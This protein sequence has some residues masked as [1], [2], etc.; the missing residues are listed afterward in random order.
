MKYKVQSTKY[1]VKSKIIISLITY[2]L[3]LSTLLGCEAF[4]K[5]FTRKPKKEQPPEEMVLVPEEYPSLF[6]NKEEAYRQYFLYWKS[7]QDELINALLV[8]MSQKKQLSCAD[9]A[10]KNLTEIKKLLIE[11][12]QKELDSYIVELT[13]LRDNIK[14]DPY[15]NNAIKNRSTAEMLKRNVLQDFSYLKIKNSLK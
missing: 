5:K 6:K 9:E 14:N 8:G 3:V 13:N 4:V 2:S 12:K 7:W 1:K 10:I 11:E 15:S